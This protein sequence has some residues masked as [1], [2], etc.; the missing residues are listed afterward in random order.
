MSVKGFLGCMFSG[1]TSHMQAEGDRLERSGKSV[2]YL[3][4]INDTRYQGPN[5]AD[6]DRKA[7]ICSHDGDTRQ[8][9]SVESLII[10]SIPHEIM[11]KILDAD[12]ICID[13]IQFMEGSVDFCQRMT[14]AENKKHILFAA[15][16]GDYNMNPF[17]VVTKLL[18]KCEKF[19]KLHAVCVE[20][21]QRAS[22]TRKIAG[23]PNVIIEIGGS[24]K[25]IPTCR[26]HHSNDI[27]ISDTAIE[28]MRQMNRKKK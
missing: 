26:I 3:K 19:K 23:D 22:F 2:I 5:G 15:L 17:P 9:Y 4:H 12:V 24:D 7:L 18:P 21:G 14:S 16:D 20:C 27:P 1:K 10:E 11:L 8:G 25:Y 13:E 6:A 28:R